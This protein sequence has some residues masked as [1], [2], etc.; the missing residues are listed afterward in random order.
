MNI[1]VIG[2]CCIDLFVYGICNRLAPDAPVPV[3]KPTGVKKNLG[4][5][6]NVLANIK[7][8]GAD[9]DLVCNKNYKPLGNG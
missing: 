9:A 1:L 7:S 8:L 6:G 3:L 4:M 2:D 5:A